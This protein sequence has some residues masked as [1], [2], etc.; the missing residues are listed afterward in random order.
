MQHATDRMHQV[1]ATLGRFYARRYDELRPQME[2]FGADFTPD[3][4]GTGVANIDGPYYAYITELS[5]G[6]DDVLAKLKVRLE[7]VPP[8]PSAAANDEVLMAGV[9]ALKWD[10]SVIDAPSGEYLGL[11]QWALYRRH[12]RFAVPGPAQLTY[13]KARGGRTVMVG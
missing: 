8:G 7:P 9:R 6:I 5:Q 1:I 11:L 13:L 10:I 4:F 2:R 3:P 12:D